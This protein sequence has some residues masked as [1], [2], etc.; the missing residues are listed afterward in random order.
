[1]WHFPAFYSNVE[2]KNINFP[3]FYSNVEHKNITRSIPKQILKQQHCPSFSTFYTIIVV[4]FTEAIHKIAL[5]DW[6]ESWHSI[7]WVY[8]PSKHPNLWAL[9]VIFSHKSHKSQVNCSWKP[10]LALKE[11]SKS[12][13]FYRPSHLRYKN[14]K[15]FWIF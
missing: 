7:Q 8:S 1:M 10:L 13:M 5:C 3:A 14:I 4:I 12:M 11:I 15:I 6:D 2:H 9:S